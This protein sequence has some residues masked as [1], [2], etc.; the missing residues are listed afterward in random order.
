MRTFHTI[1]RSVS[2]WFLILVHY[3]LQTLRCRDGRDGF[4]GFVVKAET[5]FEIP[6]PART[7]SFARGGEV[8]TITHLCCEDTIV[9]QNTVIGESRQKSS[10]EK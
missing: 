10:F 5:Q 4:G 3:I 6:P 7:T 2:G 9:I 1:H 8:R